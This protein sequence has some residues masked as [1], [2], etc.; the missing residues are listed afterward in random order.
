[1]PVVL[2]EGQTAIFCPRCRSG[3]VARER[4]PYG[5]DHCIDC[6]HKWPS[7]VSKGECAGCHQFGYV[8]CPDH[9]AGKVRP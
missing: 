7:A 9:G 2:N 8:Y 6:G 3:N 1:M 5:D 4:R